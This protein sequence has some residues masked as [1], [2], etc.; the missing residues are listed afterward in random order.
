MLLTFTVTAL[1]MIMIPGP[2]AALIMRSS[3]AHGRAAGL[4]TMAGGLIGLAAHATAA[5]IGLS[6]LLAASPAAFTALRWAG[7]AY[8]LWLGVQG[9]RA[10]GTAPA[11]AEAGAG[12]PLR[13]V[14]NGV[15]SNLLNPKV[16]LFFVTFLPQ[17]MQGTSPLLLSAIFAGLYALWFTLYNVL[18]DRVGRLLRKPKVRA[19]VER[20]TGVLLVGFAL[21]LA[22]Q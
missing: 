6:A 13:H 3:L 17:F 4:L 14:R 22:V 10:R 15:M 11:V 8:L 20:V 1:V 16:L 5:A 12:S 9:L 19:R 18:V 2:D 7:V 21:R